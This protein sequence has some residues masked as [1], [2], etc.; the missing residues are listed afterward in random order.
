MEV[1]N[2]P[3]VV[4]LTSRQWAGLSFNNSNG[5]YFYHGSFKVHC[6]LTSSSCVRAEGS[7]ALLSRQLVHGPFCRAQEAEECQVFAQKLSDL[8]VSS[9]GAN[10]LSTFLLEYKLL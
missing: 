5:K 4:L 3:A 7:A 2:A 6:E 8:M 1:L 10:L 9:G